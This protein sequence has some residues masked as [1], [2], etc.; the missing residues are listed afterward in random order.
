M[1]GMTRRTCGAHAV[2]ADNG[3]ARVSRCPCGMVHVLMKGSGVTVQLNGERF[4]ELG[5][6]VM[7]AVA[8]MGATVAVP[9]APGEPG[10]TIN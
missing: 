2:L 3:G 4:H 9:Q 8:A 6:A 7:G 10:R 5:L 1:Q